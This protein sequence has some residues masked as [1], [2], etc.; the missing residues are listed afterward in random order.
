MRVLASLALFAILHQPGEAF[1]IHVDASNPN[2]PG[3]GT[4]G[5]PY[6]SIQD[7]INA[8]LSGDTV[9]VHPGTY[10]E[11]LDFL[12]KDV[13]LLSS[14]GP[15]LTTIDAG[16]TGSVVT[17]DLGETAGAILEGFTLT[18]GSGTSVSWGAGTTHAGGGVF[19]RNSSPTIRGNVIDLISGAIYGGG[20][21]CEGGTPLIEGNT[22][23]NCITEG[24]AG[25]T[26]RIS[27]SPLIEG[28]TIEDNQAVSAG[29]GGIL[30]LSESYPTVRG[31]IIRRN[32]AV[33]GGGVSVEQAGGIIESNSIEANAADDGDGGGI[34]ADS[35]TMEISRNDIVLNTAAFSG[36]GIYFEHGDVTITDNLIQD[37]DARPYGDGGGIACL[38]NL[39]TIRG[40]RLLGNDTSNIGGG[41]FVHGSPLIQGNTIANNLSRS[42]IVCFSGAPLMLDN[43]VLDNAGDG[44]ECV[45]PSVNATIRRCTLVGN[46]YGAVFVDLGAGAE[47][48]SSILYGN[49]AGPATELFIASG[50]AT[51][52]W[53]DV[54]GGYSGAGNINQVPQFVDPLA[55]DYSLLPSS[56]CIDAGDP[57]DLDC[58]TGFGQE[59]RRLDG[60]LNGT[61]LIDIG[62]REFSN[63]YLE[64]T[65]DPVTPSVTISATGTPGLVVLLI[66]CLGQGG[67][68]TRFG[69]L[70]LD[71]TSGLFI[72]PFGTIPSSVAVYPQPQA[73]EIFTYWQLLGT[74]GSAGNVSNMFVLGSP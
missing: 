31:N 73:L 7:G 67:L 58:G 15:A 13:H 36:G 47:I 48:N 20:I 6:C 65:V 35:S 11:T 17:F 43:L 57:A 18:G 38:V 19:C 51:V 21:F 10:L 53:S 37:N 5:N 69:P 3:S 70:L 59:P 62:V 25:I 1:T 66:G 41:M 30:I 26:L 68:C 33:R 50:T 56:P 72:I 44:I 49:G 28:N 16:A 63:I 52:A 22:I 9:L 74:Q 64:M 39:A 24:G 45:G 55:G 71:Q 61:R 14:G 60:L 4:V 29:G 34:S 46:Q 23:S 42:G 12:G 32:T 8:A 2:C 54:L 27:S 40:N